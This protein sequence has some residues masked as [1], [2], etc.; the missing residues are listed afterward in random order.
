MPARQY[1][2]SALDATRLKMPIWKVG[3]M[4]GWFWVVSCRLVS[5]QLA[6][7]YSLSALDAWRLKMPIW[8]LVHGASGCSAPSGTMSH[9][10]IIICNVVSRLWTIKG[11]GKSGLF[12]SLSALKTPTGED[13]IFAQVKFTNKHSG[14]L[15]FR[16]IFF[17]ISCEKQNLIWIWWFL[18][19]M[20]L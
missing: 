7:Q 2:L 10:P 8:R 16:Q 11:K 9:Q 3:W 19:K 17:S 4:A 20:C 6:R 1:S 12:Y 5:F 14:A 18:L 13:G 15:L